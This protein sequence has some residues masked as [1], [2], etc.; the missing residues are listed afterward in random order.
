MSLGLSRMT[1]MYRYFFSFASLMYRLTLFLLSLPSE[2]TITNG[3]LTARELPAF[4]KSSSLLASLT[5][6]AIA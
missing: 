1:K 5:K 4:Y 2:R 3:Q 6:L